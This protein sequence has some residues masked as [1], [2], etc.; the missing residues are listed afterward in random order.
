M[1][2]NLFN[3]SLFK[4]RR[5]LIVCETDTVYS[6]TCPDTGLLLA[7]EIEVPEE[8]KI[9]VP[10]SVAVEEVEA[11]YKAALPEVKFTKEEIYEEN[12]RKYIEYQES[13]GFTFE[14][15]EPLQ[16]IQIDSLKKEDME[17][18]DNL[19]PDEGIKKDVV[20]ASGL[21]IRDATR[22]GVIEYIQDT[23]Y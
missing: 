5:E 1:I 14:S 21:I 19:F 4:R 2:Q 3:H 8:I 18:V 22:H 16:E 12:K 9:P 10:M 11:M 20:F 15:K 7:Y 6:L 23:F 17:L 13:Q